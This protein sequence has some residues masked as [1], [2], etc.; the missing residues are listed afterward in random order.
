MFE[1]LKIF[2]CSRL[3][4]LDKILDEEV[5]KSSP[6]LVRPW[7]ALA[8]PVTLSKLRYISESIA[9]KTQLAVESLPGVAPFRHLRG[10]PPLAQDG[11]LKIAYVSYCFSA[12]PTSFLI[13]GIF[14]HHSRTRFHVMCLALNPSDGSTERKQIEKV[15]TSFLEGC[16]HQ[17]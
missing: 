7:H 9:R 4:R 11:R 3:N 8:Y 2:F 16:L 14:R 13:S 1:V 10:L 12:H 15:P 5:Q 17:I 6:S